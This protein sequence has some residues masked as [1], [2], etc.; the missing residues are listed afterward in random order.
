MNQT[1]SYGNIANGALVDGNEVVL[2]VVS[3]PEPSALESN[4][5]EAIQCCRDLGVRAAAVRVGMND[6]PVNTVFAPSLYCKPLQ[7]LKTVCNDLQ[8]MR[9]CVK[10]LEMQWIRSVFQWR[11]KALVVLG[12]AGSS[13]VSHPESKTRPAQ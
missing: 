2:E 12:V 10:W 6:Q 5:L 13:P 7:F 4:G 9:T 1:I 8:Y 3:V 11:P